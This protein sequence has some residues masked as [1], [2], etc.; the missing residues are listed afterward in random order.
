MH[1]A[2]PALRVVIEMREDGEIPP[3]RLQ[4]CQR[5]ADRVLAP[6]RRRKESARPEAEMIADANQTSRIGLRSRSHEADIEAFKSRK[7]ERHSE[8]TQEMTTVDE[9][10]ALCFHGSLGSDERFDAD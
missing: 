4:R 5:L 10:E 7:C 6:C 8:S 9:W 2:V 1:R 3:M